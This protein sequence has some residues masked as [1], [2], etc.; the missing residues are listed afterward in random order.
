MA[1]CKKV[2]AILLAV[3]LLFTVS[4]VAASAVNTDTDENAAAE[5]VGAGSGITVHYYCDSGTPSIYYWNS[6]PTNME[7]AYPG[8]TMTAE[9]NNFYKYT[10]SNVTK[11]NMLFVVNGVQSEELTRNTGE[12]WYKNKRWFDHDPGIITQ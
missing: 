10:F 5:P 11:I 3:C 1:Q 4:A 6:L 7:T 2:L 12:W 8:K 9:S